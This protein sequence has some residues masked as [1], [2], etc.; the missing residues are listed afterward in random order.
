MP[1]RKLANT[2]S[3]RALVELLA[4]GIEV[5]E[6]GP[7]ITSQSISTE[8]GVQVCVTIAWWAPMHLQ[9]FDK[10]TP[11]EEQILRHAKTGPHTAKRLARLCER[12]F[13]SY[14]RA[15]LGRLRR[16]GKIVRSEE[17]WSVGPDNL[18]NQPR[19]KS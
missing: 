19:G 3:A 8:A 18:T 16:E 14:F 17:G 15:E 13:N 11:L 10:T 12:P 1:C 2:L 9:L 6:G 5:P 7:P 4:S